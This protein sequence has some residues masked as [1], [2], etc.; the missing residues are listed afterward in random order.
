MAGSQGLPGQV[1][2]EIYYNPYNP[3]IGWYYPNTWIAYDFR[4]YYPPGT[5]FNHVGGTYAD[6]SNPN[7]PFGA[8]KVGIVSCFIQAFYNWIP[9]CVDWYAGPGGH[10]E[11]SNGGSHSCWTW[12]STT[13]LVHAVGNGGYHFT[14]WSDNDTNEWKQV[15]NITANH[16][17]TAYFEQDAPGPGNPEYALTVTNGSGDGN[18]QAGTDVA[19]VADAPATGYHF[20]AWSGDI[21]GIVDIYAASTSI[22][23]QVAIAT[24]VATYALNQVGPWTLT[25]QLD[26]TGVAPLT[27]GG[28]EIWT[29]YRTLTYWTGSGTLER[30]TSYKHGGAYSAK[31]SGG[32]WSYQLQVRALTAGVTYR[33]RGWIDGGSAGCVIII[34]S[35]AYE[36][37]WY[38]LA[39]PGVSEYF[40][41]YYTADGTELYFLFATWIYSGYIF[42]DDLSIEKVQQGTIVGASSQIITNGANGSAVTAVPNS[43]YGFTTWS[44]G[45]KT[46]T[47]QDLNILNNL[48][49]TAYFTSIAW[50]GYP[51]IIMF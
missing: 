17:Y 50:N 30:E 45:V 3:V 31:F 23:T 24:I 42:V 39:A 22:H 2:V 37:K 19:I 34:E 32:A 35:N 14:H 15:I 49:V 10:I 41:E 18:Y 43:G 36:W 9:Y 29:D 28:M 33:I 48:T 4:P 6:I 7:S 11:Y 8:F 27:D 13:W 25:Y 38:H 44:D 40:D 21:A 26:Q 51:K 16:S 12:G 47:R 46:A 1:K 20:Q 5:T